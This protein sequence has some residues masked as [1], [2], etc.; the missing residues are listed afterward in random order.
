MD[1]QG[2]VMR[3]VVLAVAVSLA[4]GSPV[5][6]QPDKAEAV[7]KDMR[8]ALGGDRLVG[9][10]GVTLEGTFA[11]ELGPSR[12]AGGNV[13]LSIALPD[14]MHRSQVLTLQGNNSYSHVTATNGTVAWEDIK[15]SGTGGGMPAAPTASGEQS[16]DAL[17]AARLGRTRAELAR[18]VAAFLGATNLPATWVSTAAS[19]ANKADVLELKTGPDAT[20]K[21][22]VD[23]AN[24][25]PMM[26]QYQDA[27]PATAGG[28]PP[29]HVTLLL[30][31]FKEVDG[32]KVPH[33]L[34]QVVDGKPLEEWTLKRIRFN[35]LIWADLFDRK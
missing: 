32:V 21:L 17:E 5:V 18:Y 19:G 26:M 20:T 6:A 34:V 31:D 27:R 8:Q 33:R 3:S 12:R 4:F 24:H 11:R 28:P 10:K 22:F 15:R 25:M 14:K 16:P 13:V 23:Q 1:G 35:P 2:G 7:L 9:A 29:S 30:A